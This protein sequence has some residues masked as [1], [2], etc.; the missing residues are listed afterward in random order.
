MSYCP[1]C[2]ESIK[3][4]DLRD[5]QCPNCGAYLDTET[6]APTPPPSPPP[7]SPPPTTTYVPPP[8]PAIVPKD[9]RPI[10]VSLIAIITILEG[11]VF[12]GVGG[13]VA[14][15]GGVADIFWIA[16]V[17]I[18]VLIFG[19]VFLALGSGLWNLKSWA[20]WLTILFEILGIIGTLVLAL[21]FP[22]TFILTILSAIVL[23]YLLIV[24]KYFH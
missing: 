1:Y 8:P 7:S 24:K 2:G 14:L 20:W 9:S 22:P 23:L 17:G 3:P 16:I 13:L 21:V 10:G 18:L 19:F 4:S 6:I 5:N 11:I 12:L 15:A